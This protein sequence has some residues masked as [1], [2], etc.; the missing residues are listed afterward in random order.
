MLKRLYPDPELLQEYDAIIKNKLRQGIVE[1]VAADHQPSEDKKVH[2]LPHHPVIRRDKLTSKV[3]IVYD[4]SAQAGGPSLNDVLL[5]GPNL[6]QS[7]FDII[8]RFRTHQVALVDD[9]EKAFLMIG[10][11]EQDRDVLRFLW[12]RDVTTRPPEIV[13]LRF[14]RVMFGVTASPFLLNSTI[15]HHMEQYKSVDPIFVEKF[16]RS[17]YIDDVTAGSVDVQQAYEF[18]VKSKMRLAEAGFNLHKFLTNSVELLERISA[19]EQP[20]TATT[21]AQVADQDHQVLGVVWNPAKD[22]LIFDISEVN[23][24]LDLQHPMKR[25]VIGFATRFYDP[26][27]MMSPITVNFKMFFQELCKSKIDWDELLADDL[28][29]V[30]KQLTSS[31]LHAE[32]IV[33]P[34]CYSP[35]VSLKC[36]VP[37]KAS[38]MLQKMHMQL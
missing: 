19:V 5:T 28:L 31:I 26:L 29:P 35:V 27:G 24:S 20:S 15:Q 34:R 13:E 18:F 10:V 22:Q 6:N 8:I 16:L 3:R 25:Q 2:Y 1:P 14:T 21:T 36:V 33:V 17:I 11:T 9:I 7:I 30:W 4:A 12:M 23:K 37:C 32:P 38:A